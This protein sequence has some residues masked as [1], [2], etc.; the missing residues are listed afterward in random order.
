MLAAQIPENLLIYG[1]SR[2]TALENIK[3]ILNLTLNIFDLSV[4]NGIEGVTI[5]EVDDNE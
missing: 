5:N 4:I 2:D 3:Q 1:E